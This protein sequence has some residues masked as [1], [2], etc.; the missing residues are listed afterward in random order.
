MHSFDY[1]CEYYNNMSSD[2]PTS[3]DDSSGDYVTSDDDSS[4][5]YDGFMDV[6]EFSRDVGAI[7][8]DE[9]QLSL[10]WDILNQSFY[11]LTSCRDDWLHTLFSLNAATDVDDLDM[12]I[13]DMMFKT[14]RTKWAFWDEFKRGKLDAANTA[15]LTFSDQSDKMMAFASE[16]L[17]LNYKRITKSIKED[18]SI[19]KLWLFYLKQVITQTEKRK[20]RRNR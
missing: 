20:R 19:M 2:Y 3:D 12:D 16:Y 18:M 17:L 1:R 9:R 6:A 8:F 10:L 15:F 7:G 14:Y 13:A 5:E 4:G 11:E